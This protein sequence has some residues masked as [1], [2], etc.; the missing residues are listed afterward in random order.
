M[1][2]TR[3]VLALCCAPFL[4]ENPKVGEMFPADAIAKAKKLLAAFKG[5][6]GAYSDSRGNPLVSNLRRSHT[7]WLA[8]DPPLAVIDCVVALSVCSNR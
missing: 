8:I 1:T 2:W 5:G 6:V 7:G 3:Q 4:L